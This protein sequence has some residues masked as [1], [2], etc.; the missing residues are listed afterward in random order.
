MSTLL[1]NL[2]ALVLVTLGIIAHV[3]GLAD[4]YVGLIIGAGLTVF[5]QKAGVR[6]S[7][8]DATVNVKAPGGA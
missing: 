8:P 5:Q 1:D 2:P 3:L 6:V 7:A 4:L